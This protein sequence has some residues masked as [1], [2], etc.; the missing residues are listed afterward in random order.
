M[1]TLSL[2]RN[3]LRLLRRVERVPVVL[4][5]T[6]SS[7]ELHAEYCKWKAEPQLFGKNLLVELRYSIHEAFNEPQ[8]HAANLFQHFRRGYQLLEALQD[9]SNNPSETDLWERLVQQAVDKRTENLNASL[10]DQSLGQHKSEIEVNRLKNLEP[11]AAKRRVSWANKFGEQIPR[12][13][14]LTNS[15]KRDFCKQSLVALRNNAALVT[16]SY[17]KKS[18]I[19]GEIPNPYKLPYVPQH[20]RH[21]AVALPDSLVLIPHSTKHNIMKAAYDLDY[22][23]SIL[24]PEIEHKLNEKQVLAKARAIVEEKGP[25]KVQIRAS[26]AGVMPTSFLR[27][28]YHEKTYLKEMAMDIKKLMRAVR[29]R[30]VWNFQPASSLSVSEPQIGDGYAVRGSKGHLIDEIMYTRCYYENLVIKEAEWEHLMLLTEFEKENGPVSPK[31][32]AASQFARL[33]DELLK[34][35]MEPLDVTTSELDIEIQA[36]YQKYN[37][38]KS[39]PIWDRRREL[40]S[41]MNQKYERETRM[42]EELYSL[43]ETGSVFLHSDLYHRKAL[44]EDHGFRKIKPKLADTNLGGPANPAAGQTLGEHLEQKGFHGYRTGYKYAKRLN[45]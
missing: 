40:Q 41:E 44:H 38:S 21:Q 32:L 37:I 20:V 31:S 2:Y 22:V 6:L 33:K 19:R 35:W 11:L 15:E 29:K 28:P 7:L 42:L 9:V 45:I 18:Q 8:L 26:T 1:H 16:R 3:L 39:S 13:D 25:Y 14:S 36:F 4:K 10:Q 23:A 24:R 43:F 34:Q 30:F 12:Y 17:L 27:L 5:D